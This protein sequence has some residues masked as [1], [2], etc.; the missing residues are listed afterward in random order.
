MEIKKVFKPKVDKNH[1]Y[2]V[3]VPAEGKR[4]MSIQ[5]YE[6]LE[7]LREGYKHWQEYS[8]KNKI[9]APFPIEIVVESGR[10]RVLTD[11]LNE[12]N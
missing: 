7:L 4:M 8:A 1:R 2:C 12:K 3:A 5:S 10:I 9:T 11:I 6:T